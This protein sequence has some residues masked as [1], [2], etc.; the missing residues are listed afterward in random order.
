M[1]VRRKE[2]AWKKSRKFGDVK[3]GRK[4]PKIADNILVRYHSIKPPT[5]HDKLPIVL[6]DNPSKN[7]YFPIEEGEILQNIRELPSEY[8]NGLTHIWLRRVAGKDHKRGIRGSGVNLIVINAF[9]KNFRMWFG[10]KKPSK[11]TLKLYARWTDE[12][13]FDEGESAWYLMWD[14]E[15]I[16]DYYLNSLFLHEIGHFVD[17]E[18]R[19]FWSKAD[20]KKK[21]DFA[22]DFALA[23]NTRSTKA[24]PN[25]GK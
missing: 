7:F 2:S 4:F 16:K 9:P 12:L 8:T 11:G 17:S 14:E 22:D 21:E 6:R 15:T 24:L 1:Q 23:A 19:R 10:N 18:S 13:V 3:G 25:G 5:Q 20:E